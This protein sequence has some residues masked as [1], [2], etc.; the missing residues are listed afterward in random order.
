[1]KLIEKK[2]FVL[3]SVLVGISAVQTEENRFI[4]STNTCGVTKKKAAYVVR[5][6]EFNRGDYPWIVSLTL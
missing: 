3:I 4:R 5:G 1:M 2:I 6:K